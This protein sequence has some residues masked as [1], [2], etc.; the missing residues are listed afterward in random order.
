[1]LVNFLVWLVLNLKFLNESLSTQ[2][3]FGL[4]ALEDVEI[5]VASVADHSIIQLNHKKIVI[6]N[7]EFVC[8][9]NKKKPFLSTDRGKSLAT[10]MS[11]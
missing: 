10:P 7:Q 5:F 11:R 9:Q 6:K 4:E 8:L 1:M 3:Y 2:N